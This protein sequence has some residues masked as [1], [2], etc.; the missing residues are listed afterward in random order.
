M[1]CQGGGGFYSHELNSPRPWNFYQRILIKRKHSNR[2][3]ELSNFGGLTQD[4]ELS[5]FF[6]P[7][8][9]E[10]SVR[11]CESPTYPGYDLSLSKKNPRGIENRSDLMKVRVIQGT[12]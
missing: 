9:R 4:S 3:F 2:T 12:T 10:I 7:Q 8:G 6:W 5:R 11:L 1:S